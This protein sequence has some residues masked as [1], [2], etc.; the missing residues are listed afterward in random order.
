M[1]PAE[2][3]QNQSQ[4]NILTASTGE[5]LIHCNKYSTY[6]FSKSKFSDDIMK[7][8]FLLQNR[9]LRLPIKEVT[10]MIVDSSTER[11]ETFSKFAAPKT[12]TDVVNMLGDQ[13]GKNHTVFR[14][15]SIVRTIAAGN[16]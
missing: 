11:H 12:K 8:F 5:H 2:I 3:N 6:N 10:G 1:G 9:Y 7:F 15:N 4:L 13:S 14:D 16:Q